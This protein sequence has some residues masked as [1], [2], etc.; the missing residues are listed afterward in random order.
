[1][2]DCGI[3]RTSQQ[4]RGQIEVVQKMAT[5]RIGNIGEAKAIAKFVELGCPVYLPFGDQEDK[6]MIVEFD[7][8]LNRIQVKTST[9]LTKYET[10]EFKLRSAHPNRR[11]SNGKLYSKD[12]IDYFVCYSIA[13]DALYMLKVPDPPMTSFSVRRTAP[14]NGSKVGNYE[15]DFLLENAL[16]NL[17]G[18]VAQ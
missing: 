17:Q 10:V 13:W 12:D 14:K 4:G 2:S 8:R 3:I 1:M 6:D 9:K 11:S 16:K 15:K 5:K 7:G 18:S